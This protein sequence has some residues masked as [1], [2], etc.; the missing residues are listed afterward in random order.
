VCES[1]AGS[2]GRLWGFVVHG[3]LHCNCA[4][5]CGTVTAEHRLGPQSSIFPLP[6]PPR[7]VQITVKWR[8]VWR[9]MSLLWLSASYDNMHLHRTSKD[10]NMISPNSEHL[11]NVITSLIS[12]HL[13]SLFR[14]SRNIWRHYFA[15]LATSDVIISLISQHLTDVIISLIVLGFVDRASLRNLVNKANLVRNLFLVC[16]SIPTCF[17]PVC[18]HHQEIQL[19]LCDTW[20]LLFWNK[21]HINTAVSPD[22]GHTVARKM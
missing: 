4:V 20:Y 22:D 14:S 9:N 2:E 10:Y 13:T 3:K 19:C 12:Q 21:C 7:D 1:S 6:S 17:G 11:T 18:A 15:H 8:S 16:L 5:P